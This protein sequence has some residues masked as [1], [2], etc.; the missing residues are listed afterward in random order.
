MP[1]KA[2]H[3]ALHTAKA[4]DMLSWQKVTDG[5]GAAILRGQKSFRPWHASS[6]SHLPPPDAFFSMSHLGFVT[7]APGRALGRGKHTEDGSH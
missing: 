1:P 7:M 4:Q 2:Q 3:K 6:G 5:G